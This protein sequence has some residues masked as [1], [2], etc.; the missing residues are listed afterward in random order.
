MKIRRAEIKD[1]EEVV[2][3]YYCLIKDVYPH[4]PT[5]ARLF[6]YNAVIK[7]VENSCDIMVA[8]ADNGEIAG[9]TLCYIKD[10]GIYDP[11]YFG[12]IAYVKPEYRHSKASY[13]LYRSGSDMAKELNMALVAKAYVG[14]G[15]KNKVD[16]IQEKFGMK[17]QFVEYERGA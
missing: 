7:W 16:Q 8:E 12:D 2:E 11:Y 4:R 1:F 3:M 9:F 17:P 14:H 6:F 13:L 15:N 5:K 10:E